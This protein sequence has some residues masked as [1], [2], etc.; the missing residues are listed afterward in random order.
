MLLDNT[1]DKSV[2]VMVATCGG[3]LSLASALWLKK[4]GYSVRCFSIFDE[5]NKHTYAEAFQKKIKENGISYQNFYIKTE[6][7]KK[8]LDSALKTYMSGYHVDFELV[9][10]KEILIPSSFESLEKS[11]FVVFGYCA[12]IALDPVSGK[13]FL[14]KSDKKYD[15]SSLLFFLEEDKLKKIYLPL[16]ILSDVEITQLLEKLNIAESRSLF[17]PSFLKTS[18]SKYISETIPDD[19]KL[20]GKIRDTFGNVLGEHTNIY[21]YQVGQVADVKS[22]IPLYVI[23]FSNND[24][25]VGQKENLLCSRF[26]VSNIVWSQPKD[27]SKFRKLSVKIGK[28]ENKAEISPLSDGKF[29]MILSVPKIVFKGQVVVFYERDTVLGGGI[30]KEIINESRF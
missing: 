4:R 11:E 24:V 13:H 17:N 29:E 25:I 20:K 16:S 23:N 27:S 28:D 1:L 2:P 12:R 7:L 5:S 9:F 18:F 6:K 22:R 15:Q 30:I 19:L 14:L 10:H 21:S 3:S 26:I 8:I